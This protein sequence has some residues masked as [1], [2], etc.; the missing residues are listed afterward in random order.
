MKLL[1][2]ALAAFVTGEMASETASDAV[3]GFRRRY[4]PRK[5]RYSMR[6][7]RQKRRY[8]KRARGFLAKKQGERKRRNQRYLN[9][10]K[11]NGRAQQ[12]RRRRAATRGRRRNRQKK[13]E[14]GGMN[15]RFR[16]NG[17]ALQ[18]QRRQRKYMAFNRAERRNQRG[19][20]DD[21]MGKKKRRN[22]RNR[23]KI[24]AGSKKRFRRSIDTGK[25]T[26]HNRSN[27]EYDANDWKIGAKS[28]VQQNDSENFR[29]NR[30]RHKN[31]YGNLGQGVK[32]SHRDASAKKRQNDMNR[33]LNRTNQRGRFSDVGKDYKKFNSDSKLG[34]RSI[35]NAHLKKNSDIGSSQGNRHLYGNYFGEQGS[36]S[37]RNSR[38][39][40]K[41]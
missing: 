32:N 28:N 15:G 7:Q 10:R 9:G 35:N 23:N 21:A 39:N 18:R 34:K 2:L 4:F 29:K 38:S 1:F 14:R 12:R 8:N 13:F 5:N 25:T 36:A 40:N 33:S 24:N 37:S 20:S 22:Y 3:A 16:K 26:T 27:T 17:K 30:R 41:N 11:F 19:M 31:S 6:D